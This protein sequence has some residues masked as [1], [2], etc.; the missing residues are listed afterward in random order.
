MWDEF[1]IKF[2]NIS[3]NEKSQEANLRIINQYFIDLLISFKSIKYL[4]P[5]LLS[6]PLLSPLFHSLSHK[7]T[8]THTHTLSTLPHAAYHYHWPFLVRNFDFSGAAGIFNFSCGCNE[9]LQFSFSWKGR[10][11]G[12]LR[13]LL[14]SFCFQSVHYRNRICLIFR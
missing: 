1:Y 14:T 2:K 8:L 7:H 12:S 11:S 13:L 5:C 10:E 9:M 6:L 4:S 3:I